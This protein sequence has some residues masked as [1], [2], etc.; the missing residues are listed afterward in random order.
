[1]NM[2]LPACVDSYR[3]NRSFVSLVDNARELQASLAPEEA[4]SWR[5]VWDA[6][7]CPDWEA[8][9]CTAF[10]GK[11]AGVQACVRACVHTGVVAVTNLI[12]KHVCYLL[13]SMH[14]GQCEEVFSAPTC[15]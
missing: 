5:C 9:L 3:L 11:W 10:V 15:L 6:E 12:S 1:M 8:Y 13:S 2:L 4:S 14:V 7:T